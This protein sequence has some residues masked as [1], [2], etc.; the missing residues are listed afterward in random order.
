[1]KLSTFYTKTVVR[2]FFGKSQV[3]TVF[4]PWSFQLFNSK[5]ALPPGGKNFEGVRWSP[6]ENREKPIYVAWTVLPWQ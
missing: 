3:L 4:L 5:G 2:M 6:G 1:M